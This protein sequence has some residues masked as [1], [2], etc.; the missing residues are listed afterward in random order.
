MNNYE[1][2]CKG[3]TASGERFDSQICTSPMGLNSKMTSTLIKK[4]SVTFLKDLIKIE[5]KFKRKMISSTK[6]IGKKYT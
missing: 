3:V 4:Y 5:K 1:I 6:L 2:Y